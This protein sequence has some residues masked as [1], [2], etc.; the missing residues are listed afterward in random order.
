MA[1]EGMFHALLSSL[2]GRT[3]L[4]GSFVT[5]NTSA[6]T[7]KTGDGVVARASAGVFTVTL[8]KKFGKEAIFCFLNNPTADDKIVPKCD[9]VT[10]SGVSVLTITV[11]DISGAAATETTGL[12]INWA[13]I[14]N[15][16]SS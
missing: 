6:P 15:G 2:R 13:L 3:L 8:P 1:G 11:W 7:G 9:H 5:A 10:T 16:R 14:A 4:C 12:D